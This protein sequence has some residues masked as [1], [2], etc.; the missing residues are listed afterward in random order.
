MACE[1]K[2]GCGFRKVGGI[3][4]VSGDA[5]D[6]CDRLPFPIGYCPVCHEGMKFPRSP[7]EI[8]PLKLLGLHEQCTETPHDWGAP[9]G[10]CRVCQPTEEVAYLLGV[11]EQFYKTPA[12]FMEEAHRLGISKRVAAI[13]KKLEVGKTWVYLVHRHAMY[14]QDNKPQMAVFSAFIPKAIEMPVWASEVGPDGKMLDAEKQK[15]FDR[16]HITPV[17]MPD[18][19]PDHAPK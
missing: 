15:D 8:N 14:D 18:G 5:W 13:P 1:A 11:G 17:P 2:R 16:R 3:Y 9:A 19:D 12:I 7:R 6:D 10:A 4:L